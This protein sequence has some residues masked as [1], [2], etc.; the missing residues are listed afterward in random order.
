MENEI[1]HSESYIYQ[2]VGTKTSFSTPSNYFDGL[3]QIIEA[4]ISEE[5][6][7]KETAFEVPEH[8]FEALESSILSKVSSTTK[9]TKI[10]SLKNNIYKIIPFV[11][12]ASIMLFIGLN[13]FVF[14]TNDHLSLESLSSN[15][16]EYWLEVNTLSTDDIATILEDDILEVNEFYFTDIKDKSIEEYMNSL[17][18]NT[19]WNELN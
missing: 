15:D 11:A 10:I 9:Q 5:K 6:F 19:L 8:Y 18:S 16:L 12:A 17:D 4:K 7:S 14:N 3:E 2:T 13:S 1:K